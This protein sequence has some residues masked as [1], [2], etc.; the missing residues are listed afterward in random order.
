MIK[1]TQRL[2]RIIMAIGILERRIGR[3]M[4]FTRNDNELTF[5]LGA[6]YKEAGNMRKS[7]VD[8]Y[9]KQ[10]KKE[11]EEEA[12]KLPSSSLSSQ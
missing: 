9:R 11:Q 10:E 12:Q 8:L 5:A 4:C 2:H 6:E 1:H 7:V 3:E